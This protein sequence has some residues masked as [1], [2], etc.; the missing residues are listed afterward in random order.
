MA[1][2][3]ILVPHKNGTIRLKMHDN[4]DGTFSPFYGGTIDVG[5][6]VLTSPDEGTY[7]GDVSIHEAIPN[8]SN[9]IG[10]VKVDEF[11]HDVTRTV[12]SSEDATTPVQL[13]AAAGSGNKHVITDIVFS[14]EALDNSDPL[15]VTIKE[16]TSDDVL[17]QFAVW[18]GTPFV[19][20]PKGKLKQLT[21][22]KKL[23][24]QA[25]DASNIHVMVLHYAET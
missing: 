6:L 5:E 1:D 22:N 10:A 15:L 24:I 19:F 21:A 3:Y 20:Q 8:G 9:L 11:N 14:A 17:L 25:S 13:L 16:E 2:T 23:Y 7:V 12:V 18:G 4:G